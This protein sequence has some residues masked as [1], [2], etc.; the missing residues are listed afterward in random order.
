MTFR[1][2]LSQKVTMGTVKKDTL[3]LD[4]TVKRIAV[5]GLNSQKVWLFNV[6]EKSTKRSGRWNTFVD[7]VLNG[8]SINA[9]GEDRT[10][11]ATDIYKFIHAGGGVTR[12][13]LH[14]DEKRMAVLLSINQTVE[15]WDIRDVVRLQS[16][17]VPSDSCHLLWRNN[18]L[19]TAPLYSGVIQAVDTEKEREIR[20]IVGSIRRRSK[21]FK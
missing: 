9:S 3:C 20:A 11:L 8:R 10:V 5:G 16:H 15:V 4:A 19:L 13:K 18:V 14:S 2:R 7:S 6:K 17:S 1:H 12:V 21:R